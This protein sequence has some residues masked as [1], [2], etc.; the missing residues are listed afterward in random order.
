M[1]KSETIE[2][3]AE[4]QGNLFQ[5]P[6]PDGFRAYVRSHKPKGL[7]NKIMTEQEAVSK[8]VQDGDYTVVDCNMFQRG[9]SS[10]VREVIRQRK[11]NLGIAGRFTYM[12]VAVLTAGGCLDRI[13]VGFIGVSMAPVTRALAAGTVKLAEWTNS[14][15]TM[16]LQAGAM[17]LPYM[18][19]RFLGGT[20]C[21]KYSGAKLATDPFT[22][23][24]VTLLP[25]LN[26]D[27]ALIHVHQCDMYGNARIFGSN[28]SPKEAA[29]ASKK[30]II[31]TEEI[32]DTEDIRRHPGNT[33]IP[34]YL[35][36]AVVEAPF[37]GYP[38]EVQ[39]VYLSDTDHSGKLFM[40][41]NDKGSDLIDKYLQE[42]VW[43]VKSHQDFLEK[44]GLTR[45]MELR[46]QAE[47]KEGY[48]L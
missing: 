29:G 8:F 41:T 45:L 24:P 31:S 19:A 30:V 32:I 23:K 27:V 10:L 28:I 46:R 35:V 17:G 42:Y 44:I 18:P 21:F 22:G 15:L 13:D 1:K 16:R 12:D 43:G 3:I 7:V 47:I 11:K 2:I 26:P 14:G 6:D 9:P 25:A 4:G 37:G 5:P 48:R 39:G 36:D 20:D 34:Y 40:A 33:T 38:G